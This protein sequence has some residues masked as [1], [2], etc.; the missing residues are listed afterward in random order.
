M[1]K[2]IFIV[3]VF[4]LIGYLSKILIVDREELTASNY[5]P[6]NYE[7]TTQV[8]RGSIYSADGK[9]LAYTTADEDGSEVRKYPYGEVFAHVVG[10]VGRGRSGLEEAENETLTTPTDFL[11]QL[12]SW[13]QEEKVTGRGIRTTLDC[14]LQQYIYSQMDGY[15]GAVVMTDPETGRILALVSTPS[16]DPE[17][18]SENWEAIEQDET[19][20]LYSRATMGLY[21][22]GSTFK[23]ITA[24]AMYRYMPDYDTYTYDCVNGLA[25]DDTVIYCH[26]GQSHGTEDIVSGFADSCNGF[27]GS[28]ALKM[29]AE[30]LIETAS[31][32]HFGDSFDFILPQ[33]VSTMSLST[34]DSDWML[35]ETAFGQGETLV[36]P[37]WLNMFT[38][39][40]ANAGVLE[41]P[42]LVDA[43]LN[44][45]GSVI[46]Q[47]QPEEWGSL[48]TSEEAS[49]LQN[50][51][52]GVVTNGT[53]W[54]LYGRGYDVYGKTGTAQVEDGDSHSWF[55]GCAEKDGHKVVITVLVEHGAETHH[56]V[57]LTGDILDYYFSTLED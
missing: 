15:Q 43:V 51:M 3:L 55:T 37:F 17:T 44:G 35:A 42:Y 47:Y 10:Y 28:A 4:S 2:W 11:S 49:F 27:F 5:N 16:F 54:Q 18:I 50:L 39:S 57:P 23:I 20:P 14:D 22:P 56:A 21:P 26:N 1:I 8:I 12:K 29:G 30:A 31:S 38:C 45:D 48:I 40:I 36:T 6:I 7:E 9:V 46:T 34:S 41:K 13:A 52:Y 24:L 53:A 25:V 32:V 33:S 19:S